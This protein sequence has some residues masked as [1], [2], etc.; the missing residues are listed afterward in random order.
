LIEIVEKRIMELAQ[1][2]HHARPT[3]LGS[4]RRLRGGPVRSAGPA[5]D[6]TPASEY[7]RRFSIDL[8]WSG[9][10]IPFGGAR[11]GCELMAAPATGPAEVAISDVV[12]S[13]WPVERAHMGMLGRRHCRI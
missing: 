10:V 2:Y 8:K 7:R 9:S 13:T 12:T 11:G 3:L 5:S 1:R 6:R 4:V